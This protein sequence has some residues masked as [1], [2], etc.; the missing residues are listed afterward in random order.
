M[1]SISGRLKAERERVGLSQQALADL[2]GI[3]LRSQQ[4][5]EKG[6]RSPDADYL[7]AIAARGI[8]IMYVL[9]GQNT[10]SA[11]S[12]GALTKEDRELLREYHEADADGRSI[13]RSVLATSTPGLKLK[14]PTPSAFGALAAAVASMGKQLAG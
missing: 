6:D 9:T 13:A 1:R 2:C 12:A 11:S 8:D 10:G 5:Y 4:N 3:S 7:A 14:A